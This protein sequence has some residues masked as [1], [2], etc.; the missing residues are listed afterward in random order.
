VR[1]G[2][3]LLLANGSADPLGG[4]VR[5]EALDAL[6]LVGWVADTGDYW[7]RAVAGRPGFD[8]EGASRTSAWGRAVP[9]DSSSFRSPPSQRNDQRAAPAAKRKEWLAYGLIAFD[10]ARLALLVIVAWATAVR[11]PLLSGSRTSHTLSLC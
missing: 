9:V 7:V 5:R 1:A 4:R 11:S 10:G 8:Q 3:F 6:A 2:R